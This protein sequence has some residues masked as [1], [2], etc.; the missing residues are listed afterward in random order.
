[1]HACALVSGGSLPRRS[2]EGQAGKTG[3]GKVLEARGE[4]KEGAGKGKG[5]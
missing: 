5:Q 2:G 3:A 4:G 1:V